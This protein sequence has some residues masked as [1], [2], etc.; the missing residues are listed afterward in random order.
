MEKIKLFIF[1]NIPT[2]KNINKLEISLEPMNLQVRY[3]L[4]ILLI[5]TTVILVVAGTLS[6]QFQTSMHQV[7]ETSADSVAPLLRSQLQKQGEIM[8]K[9]LAENLINPVYQM[10]IEHVY[11]LVMAAKKQQ[12]IVSVIVFDLE[13]K[14][15]HDGEAE[16]PRY[17]QPL[18]EATP[19]VLTANTLLVHSTQETL[20]LYMPIWLAKGERLGGVQLILS[21]K[22]IY[23][24]IEEMRRKIHTIEQIG[25]RRNLYAIGLIT[26]LLM[27]LGVIMATLVARSMSRPIKKLT[28]QAETLGKGD[29][30]STICLLRKDELGV[31]ATTLDEMRSNLKSSTIEIH[32]Q[33]EEI[34]QQNR[35]IIQQN[36]A[37]KELD[38]MKDDFLANVTHELKTPLNGVLGI[39]N[40]VRDGAYGP[41]PKTLHQPMQ[42]IVD[43]ASRLLQL[44]VQILSLTSDQKKEV[45]WHKIKIHDYLKT[46]LKRF[47][48]Q[49][50]K[51]GITTALQANPDLIIHTDTHLLDMIFMNLVGNAIKFTHEGCVVIMVELI[52]NKAV[53]ISVVDT[54]IGIPKK[55][56]KKIF[57]RF[58]QGFSSENRAYEGSGLGLSIMTQAL[59]K[60]N[61]AVHLESSPGVGSTFSVLLPTHKGVLENELL[62][63]WRQTQPDRNLTCVQHV[64]SIQEEVDTLLQ[65][66]TEITPSL[67]PTEE[68]STDIHISILV[69]DDDA[70]N[71]EVVSANL[72]GHFKITEAH[73]GKQCLELIRSQPFDLILLDLMMPNISGFDVLAA[74]KNMTVSWQIP[75]VIVLSAKDQTSS[76][77][78]AFHL[79]AVDYVTKPFQREELLARIKAH[80][81]LRQ[82]AIEIMERKIAEVE[83]LKKQAIAEESNKAKGLF[84][85]NMSHEI[86]TPMNAIMGLSELALMKE[87]SPIIQ[88]YLTKILSSSRFLLQIINDILDF[89]K[90]EAG[91]LE[92]ESEPF[93]LRD[94]LESLTDLLHN[95]AIE[96]KLDFVL[97]LSKECRFAL[98][99]DAL[100]LKQIL[101]NLAGNAIKFT[102]TGYIEIQVLTIEQS[103]ERVVL[104]FIIADTGIGMSQEQMDK[105]FNPFV[106]ADSSTTR[107]FGGTGL[108]LTI[109]K[110]LVEGMGGNIEMDS[111]MGEGSIFRFSLPFERR[112]EAE[113]SEFQLPNEMQNL[114]VLV[115]DDNPIITRSIQDIL[116]TFSFIITVSHS[117]EEAY[118]IA[119]DYQTEQP[120]FKLVLVSQ[121][122]PKIDGTTLSQHIAN[123]KGGGE[124]PKI[125]LM[126]DD[127]EKNWESELYETGHE[128]EHETGVDAF[129]KK[130]INCSM[131]FDQ[132]MV[133]FG[134]SITKV[135][136]TH[137]QL[138]DSEAISQK[139][140]AAHVLL[141]DDNDINQM[142]G[143]EI[144]EQAGITVDVA[145]NG[146]QAIQRLEEKTYDAVLMDIQMPEMDGY[147]ATK[148]IRNNP[149]FKTLP[150]IAMTA[151]AMSVDR[152]NC[153]NCGMN[154][155]VSKPIDKNQLFVTLNRWIKLQQPLI[156]LKPKIDNATSFPS[157]PGI[158]TEN[159]LFRVGGNET[160]YRKLLHQFQETQEDV[161]EKVR[162][163]LDSENRQEAILTVHSL[164][165]VAGNIGAMEMY[166]VASS[167]EMLLKTETDSKQEAT[168]LATLA[169]K[170]V[171]IFAAIKTLDKNQPSKPTQTTEP[172]Q[173]TQSLDIQALTP[174]IHK[175]ATLLAQDDYY[176]DSCMEEIQ[177]K[178]AGTYIERV[179]DP[180]VKQ[181]SDYDFEKALKQLQEISSQLGIMID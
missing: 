81:T 31:L 162:Q 107:K 17:G 165:G 1:L 73:D 25:Q 164:K 135:Q 177:N 113:K 144:L 127:L 170:L 98:T 134:K 87:N 60:L 38:L 53:A 180:V 55:V 132:I 32:K 156:S 130:P 88:D 48:Y 137:E 120:P 118:A 28:H 34:T 139:M 43:S 114:K 12:E 133:V 169:E 116:E 42:H 174:L 21:L 78:R 121:S 181:I 117:A 99:G 61:G 35:E 96:K 172:I 41:L 64:P 124:T 3:A 75:S 92:L 110:R 171:P 142:V 8:A 106:Q 82:N 125:I 168:L 29:L 20:E 151:H 128:T 16:I 40:A 173:T 166:Q 62:D 100:R 179:F 56:H 7:T 36:E 95:K 65:E 27:A 178:L 90:I 71:R 54:G 13:G 123:M 66:A 9:F 84:L 152:D 145:E 160:L 97:T 46:F 23:E 74:L 146:L 89:S 150:I 136:Q 153:L 59:E 57:E 86:R 109:S 103:S 58:Q 33:N 6:Q 70:I 51:K 101:M 24:Q 104:E 67:P 167:L 49:V 163:A 147:T 5:I 140:G 72:R 154:D 77:T 19:E 138:F 85:A 129:I 45:E 37:L 161:V 112:I 47:D 115:V 50:Q 91:K 44:T 149:K 143:R 68:K 157:L 176:A 79:G 105:L 80:V 39:S 159:G 11:E 30:D 63:N 155:F 2:H 126:V 18:L 141:V 14:I 93:L 69:V 131:L 119:G 122:L 108:G 10:N 111:T 175:L 94:V 83:I 102:E 52:G 15:I 26:L 158:D 22:R 76:I 4:I 148:Q